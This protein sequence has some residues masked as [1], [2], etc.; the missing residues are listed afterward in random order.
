MLGK[1]RVVALP[2]AQLQDLLGQ[3]VSERRTE[4]R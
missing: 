2:H 4:H 1:Q 3:I